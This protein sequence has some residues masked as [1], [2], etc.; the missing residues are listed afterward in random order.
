MTTKRIKEVKNGEEILPKRNVITI[1]A[2]NNLLEFKYP[3]K[4][5]YK[6]VLDKLKSDDTASAFELLFDDCLN[7][8]NNKFDFEDKV[9]YFEELANKFLSFNEISVEI[10]DN[11]YSITVN[12]KNLKLLKPDRN[13]IKELFNLNLK[14]NI[15]SLNYIYNKLKTDGYTFDFNNIED[16]VDY[17]SMHQLAS[18]LIFNKNIEIKK[19]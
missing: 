1:S 6:N 8:L 3:N 19:K 7:L 18:I 13:Q 9:L 10:E 16:I 14:S 17:Y 15:E 11:K 4:L 12:N 2:N 5:T